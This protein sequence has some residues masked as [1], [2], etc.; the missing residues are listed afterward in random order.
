M[1]LALGA[2]I[3][4]LA[5]ARAE[6][7][8]PHVLL[9]LRPYDAMRIGLRSSFTLVCMQVLGLGLSGTILAIGLFVAG[10]LEHR[11][12]PSLGDA[13]SLRVAIVVFVG[14][15][16]LA[17]CVG[18]VVDLARAAVVREVGGVEL[19]T[20]NATA[21]AKSTSWS[22]SIRAL[23]RA[24]A[25]ARQHPTKAL[26]GWG[27][28]WGA[29]VILIAGGALAAHVWGGHEKPFWVLV[30]AHQLIALARVGLRASWLARALALIA[31][32]ESALTK[33]ADTSEAA[34]VQP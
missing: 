3:A 29:G 30:I 4:S 33:E 13:S 5:F 15:V 27:G 19:A 8:A 14:F 11:L 28:R 6:N 21:H 20:P 2:L 25:A 23:R 9:P 18:I 22:I 34:S 31:T 10:A 26:V 7:D 16:V 24:L 1:Q 12:V 32:P 17:A